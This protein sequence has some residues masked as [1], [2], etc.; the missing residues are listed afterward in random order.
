MPLICP[1]NLSGYMN[2]NVN[3]KR[4]LS[5]SADQG[6][7]AAQFKLGVMYIDGL[8]NLTK[9]QHEA[10]RL[11]KQAAANGFADATIILQDIYNVF[12]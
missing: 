4:L 1:S 10:V 6:T 9:D 2:D 5:L 8:G 12:I 11:F 3:P 7:A